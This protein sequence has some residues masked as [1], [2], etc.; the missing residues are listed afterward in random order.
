MRNALGLTAFRD[1]GVGEF[2]GVTVGH[3]QLTGAG[4][5]SG[6]SAVM[7]PAGTTASVEVRGGGP[8]SHET[9]ILTP[10]TLGYGVDAIVLTGGSAFGL[11][12]A[13]GVQNVLAQAGTGCV[14][15][16]G[17]RVPIVPAAAIYDLSRAGSIPGVHGER[18][19]PGVAAGEEAAR[20]AL[21]ARDTP[22]R[23]GTAAE[24]RGSIGAGTGAWSG[25]GFAR[26]GLGQFSVHTPQG[27]RVSAIVVANP[28][29]SIVSADGSLYA[30]GVLA[31]YGVSLPKVPAAT[32]AAHQQAAA[33]RAAAAL[34][35]TIAVIV[36]DAPLTDAQAQRLAG[37]AHAGLARAVNPSH[38]LMDGDTV[39]AAAV[40]SAAR[41]AGGAEA[42]P[43]GAADSQP[44]AFD[45]SYTAPDLTLLNVA[46]A[47]ALTLACVDAIL[48]AREYPDGAP[49]AFS[50]PALREFAPDT[51]ACWETLPAND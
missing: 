15:T 13:R 10:G 39:F 48:S 22:G 4:E 31:D 2:A 37:S 21:A 51:V 14:A 27:F 32:V 9:A 33:Q 24:V 40:P 41:T 28:A 30:A 23:V 5:L 47:D 50:P 7:L 1:R 42:D 20:A 18:G 8:A 3:A 6:T 44:A 34:N 16:P 26:G 29:G 46:A 19:I 11:A 12:S 36:T 45:D 49:T 35:T 17:V 38:T 43:A 25:R